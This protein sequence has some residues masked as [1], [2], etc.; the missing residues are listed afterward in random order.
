M[1]WLESSPAFQG[2]IITTASL[3]D[4]SNDTWDVTV[5]GTKVKGSNVAFVNHYLDD[6]AFEL[7]VGDIYSMM[8]CSVPMSTLKTFY[9]GEGIRIVID[10]NDN[11]F[12]SSRAR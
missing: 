9:V 2:T 8:T 6:L 12:V 1:S 5:K 3:T 10:V 4:V 7:P 11:Y